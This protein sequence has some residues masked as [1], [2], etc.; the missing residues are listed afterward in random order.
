MRC[1]SSEIVLYFRTIRNWLVPDFSRHMKSWN[2]KRAYFVF[3]MTIV[4]QLLPKIAHKITNYVDWVC[5][6]WRTDSSD[7]PVMVNWTRNEPS[8]WKVESQQYVYKVC[9][10]MRA[11]LQ[12]LQ[13][14]SLVWCFTIK[15]LKHHIEPAICQK[16][17]TQIC[18]LKQ[19]Q[20]CER[21]FLSD[22]FIFF[23]VRMWKYMQ[24][25]HQDLRS[26]QTNI[27]SEIHTSVSQHRGY[28]F[29]NTHSDF[30][31]F[32]DVIQ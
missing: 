30:M 31:C 20:R 21:W 19:Q 2:W 28:Y 15:P 7:S 23:R 16:H 32:M 4:V 24:P 1:C 9:D 18:D 13:Q 12:F 22:N 6:I 5:V 29:C 8:R 26:G 27:P 10:M 14:V 11:A 17:L 3:T 25:K